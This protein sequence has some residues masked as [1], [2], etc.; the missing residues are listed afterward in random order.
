[1][2]GIVPLRVPMG[3]LTQLAS[4]RGC[5]G[6]YWQARKSQHTGVPLG[7]GQLAVAGLTQPMDT[8]NNRTAAALRFALRITLTPSPCR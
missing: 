2:G 7:Q 3:T 1:M 8:M 6:G 4:C 5:C